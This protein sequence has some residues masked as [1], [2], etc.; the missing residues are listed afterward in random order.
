[1]NID[2][3]NTSTTQG[4]PSWRPSFSSLP[5]VSLFGNAR[6]FADG[7][8]EAGTAGFTTGNTK[9]HNACTNAHSHRAR[10]T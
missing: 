10:S 7:A 5:A 1:M 8:D 9:R 4:A 6:A 2:P 3:T